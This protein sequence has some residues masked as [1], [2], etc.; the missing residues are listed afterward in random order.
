M[1]QIGIPG[2]AESIN[3]QH[4]SIPHEQK[5]VCPAQLRRNRSELFAIQHELATL[6]ISPTPCPCLH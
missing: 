6:H 2:N 3:Q 4:T 5:E 1:K